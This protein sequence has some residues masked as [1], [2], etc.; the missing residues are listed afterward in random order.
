MQPI[1]TTPTTTT[2]ADF[3]AAVARRTLVRG[4]VMA[5]A[6]CAAVLAGAMFLVNSADWWRGYA[7]A[8]VASALAGGLSLIPL[9]KG[10]NKGFSAFVPAVMVATGV[11]TLVAVGGCM[12]A[13][14]AGKYPAVPTLMLMMPYYL[15]LLGVETTT[16]V[17]LGNA[18]KGNK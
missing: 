3:D 16:L 2:H 6:G 1:A 15:V 18:V 10:L 12:L 4:V 9:L 13:V 11:R 14:I 5:V 7:A 17:K 8:T